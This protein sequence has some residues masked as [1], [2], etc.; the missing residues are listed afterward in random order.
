MTHIIDK[1]IIKDTPRDVITQ[2]VLISDGVSGELNSEVLV[3][4]SSL[5]GSPDH[6]I[7]VGVMGQLKGWDGLLNFQAAIADPV[8]PIF[9]DAGFK[10]EFIPG[11]VDPMSNAY[12]GDIVLKTIGFNTAGNSGWI[13]LH[14]L[15]E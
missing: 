10:F 12:T 4:V 2:T 9:N 14:C 5:V 1:K 6:L 8:I 11:V 15:K 13:R 3:D 7:V